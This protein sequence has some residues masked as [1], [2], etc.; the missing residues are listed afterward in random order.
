MVALRE[1]VADELVHNA[2]RS[3]NRVPFVVTEQN[4]MA[5]VIEVS[6]QHGHVE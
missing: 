4:G 5:G 2:L 6:V 1:A 3:G